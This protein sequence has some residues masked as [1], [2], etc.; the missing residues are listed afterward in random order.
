MAVTT[1]AYDEV[2][3]RILQLRKTVGGVHY[4]VRINLFHYNIVARTAQKLKVRKI[5]PMNRSGW[6]GGCLANVMTK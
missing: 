2:H 1:L 6:A 3:P 4:A 5:K